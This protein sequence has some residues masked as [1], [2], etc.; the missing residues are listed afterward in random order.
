MPVNNPPEG[1]TRINPYLL[2][3]DVDAAVD[4]L[5]TTMGFTE[6]MRMRDLEGKTM[7]AEAE[8]YGQHVM[9]GCPSDGGYKNPAHLGGVTQ[10]TCVYVDDVDAHHDRALAAGATV[11]RGLADQFYGDRV[12]QVEDPEGHQ[13]S[14]GQHIRDVAPEDLHP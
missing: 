14:I 9:L 12:Y 13:W 5:V 6:T 10:L 3:E 11:V 8:I 7:H 1:F 4:W 2:Y